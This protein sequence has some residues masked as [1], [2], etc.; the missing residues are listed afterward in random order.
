MFHTWHS[1]ATHQQLPDGKRS[2]SSSHDLPHF[3]QPSMDSSHFYE[4]S[5]EDEL[6]AWGDFSDISFNPWAKLKRLSLR[7]AD[8][9]TS[10]TSFRL[11]DQSSSWQSGT[12][13]RGALS[14]LEVKPV[15]NVPVKNSKKPA[16]VPT[17]T[18]RRNV[19][20]QEG[21]GHAPEE[22]LQKYMQALLG[23]SITEGV[24]QEMDLYQECLGRRNVHQPRFLSPKPAPAP[25][26]RAL[27]NKDRNRISMTSTAS[28][29]SAVPSL[30]FSEVD[31]QARRPSTLPINTHPRAAAPHRNSIISLKSID[32]LASNRS[33]FMDDESPPESPIEPTRLKKRVN[34]TR[35]IEMGMSCFD[36]GDDDDEGEDQKETLSPQSPLLVLINTETSPELPKARKKPNPGLSIETKGPQSPSNMLSPALPLL[37]HSPT[38]PRN[39]IC[40]SPNKRRSRRRTA[41]SECIILEA[42]EKMN[43]VMYEFASEDINRKSVVG[44]DLPGN[45]V[46]VEAY[47]ELWW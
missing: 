2:S 26:K 37:T 12:L 22:D 40:A 42:L 19:Q 11:T 32:S 4:D 29:A 20:F 41:S 16:G 10:L 43:A 46:S 45:Q 1:T 21:F 9:R 28:D 47:G 38:S 44:I 8:N 36:D 30:V 5:S 23:G 25:R 34:F 35:G 39:S 27:H 18:P 13:A 17:P 31:V 3:L 14:P 6:P 7:E 15:R 24:H 33:W